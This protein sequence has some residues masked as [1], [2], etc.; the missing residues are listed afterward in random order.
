MN[1]N[2]AFIADIYSHYVGN[3]TNDS[4]LILTERNTLNLNDSELKV[5]RDHFL[6]PFADLENFQ[7]FSHDVELEM[8]EVFTLINMFFKNEKNALSISQDLSKL[9][10]K[11]SI[12][13][14]IKTGDFHFVYFNDLIFEGEIVDGVGLYK[15]EEKKDFIVS[16]LNEQE[17][18]F[19][20]QK[21][22]V[23]SQLDKGC[24]I[25]NTESENGYR[26]LLV[27]KTNRGKE[28]SFWKETFL[29][30][31]TVSADYSFTEDYMTMCNAFVKEGLSE[32]DRTEKIDLM[33][34]S[35]NYFK[36]NDTFDKVSFVKDVFSNSNLESVFERFEQSYSSDSSIVLED[37]FDI[38]KQVVSKKSRSF[39]KVLKLDNNFQIHIH[40]DKELI[41]KG[42]DEDTG[43]NY[44]KLY[45]DKET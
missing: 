21:G 40:G 23:K 8:N 12:H 32:V 20:V 24:I 11:R 4:R 2:I 35:I 15:T 13:P 44:Y 29:E 22:V 26:V 43:R 16:E 30:L 36:E 27:D 37:R 7:R 38:S 6:Q 41:E 34:R 1:Q 3:R 28:A 14:N 42:Y 25:F 18:K 17:S 5:L 9:L 19:E 31:S 10:L 33:N 45:F 39:K